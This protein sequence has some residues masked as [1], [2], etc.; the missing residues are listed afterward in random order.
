MKFPIFKSEIEHLEDREEIDADNEHRRG[1]RRP[2]RNYGAEPPRLVS[3]TRFSFA[4]F[5]PDDVAHVVIAAPDWF[6]LTMTSGR[7]LGLFPN[8]TEGRAPRA[9]TASEVMEAVKARRYA[10]TVAE[11]PL[12]LD[13]YVALVT[14][15]RAT[16]RVFSLDMIRPAEAEGVRVV[17]DGKLT[18]AGPTGARV[19]EQDGRKAVAV[20]LGNGSYRKLT[21]EAVVDLAIRRAGGFTEFTES[22]HDDR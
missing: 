13:V 20:P 14:A 11:P 16:G 12:R 7:T 15:G 8:T 22:P 2:P 4:P 17:P 5:G 6:E 9:L 10:L 19:C 3:T 18:L 21:P 1:M